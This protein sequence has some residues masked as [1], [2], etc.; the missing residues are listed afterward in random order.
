MAV[1]LGYGPSGQLRGVSSI[2]SNVSLLSTKTERLAAV[3]KVFFVAERSVVVERTWRL[4]AGLLP[5]HRPQG[6]LRREPSPP[7][8][9]TMHR[10]TLA[11]QQRHSELCHD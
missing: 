7:G 9:G 11:R 6:R 5:G 10:C 2:D 1:T 8:R 4:W 3:D